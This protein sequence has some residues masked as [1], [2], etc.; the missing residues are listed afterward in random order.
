[1]A[2]GKRGDVQGEFWVSVENMPK[3]PGD[4]FYQKL[5]GLLAEA[6]FDDWVES[7][8]REYYADKRGRP[9]I[10]PGTYFRMLLIGYFEGI[11]SQRGIAWRCSDSLS[12]RSFLG[13]ATDEDAPEH[14]SLP[15]VRKRLPLDVHQEVFEFVL[16]MAAGKNLLD[17]KTVAVD[18]TTLEANAAMKSIVRRDNGE[19]Y[20]A[21]L[22]R[23]AEAEGIEDPTDED[24]RR[25]DK[26]RKGKKTSNKEWKSS[27][28]PD[29]RVTKMKDGRTHLAYK[30]E[31]TIDLGSDVLLS[32]DV[33]YGDYGDPDSIVLS[34]I[35]S[36]RKLLA[37]GID[38]DI[39]EVVADKGYHAATTLSA[40]GEVGVGTYIQE[41]ERKHRRRWTRTS[42]RAFRRLCM[43]TG[44]V[45]E[46][47]GARGCRSSAV[48]SSNAASLTCARPV[49]V[50]APGC[51][52]LKAVRKR[53]AIQGAARNLGGILRK[54]FGIGTPRGLLY[55]VWTVFSLNFW[56]L[57]APQWR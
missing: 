48:S 52:E 10:P 17:G 5:N 51:G 49:T 19:D 27:S 40:F 24:L 56:P 21:Y 4:P 14:S 41:P 50:A 32:A 28:D 16:A 37:A 18:S 26:K 54:L 44:D 3:L 20:K 23:L 34:V 1:M 8:C 45:S 38:V 57:I 36:Q 12:L 47:I 30:G 11:T 6:G 25:F 55:V 29:S 39:R 35:E 43:P 42:P 33:Y 7:R 9:G 2:L 13:L 53:Y 15:R 46:A 22:K 31:N